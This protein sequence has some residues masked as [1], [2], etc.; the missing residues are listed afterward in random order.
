MEDNDASASIVA[1]QSPI[2]DIEIQSPPADGM[3]MMMN[4]P[5]AIHP[6]ESFNVPAAY[7]DKDIPQL[8]IMKLVRKYGAPLKMVGE[9][10][11]ILKE[12]QQRNRLDITMLTT[13]AT[14]IRRLQKMYSSLPSPVPITISHERT[15]QEM[16]SGS[17]RPS[18]TFPVFSFL[19]QLSAQRLT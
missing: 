2:R 8:R 7:Y 11:K 3:V 9:F 13:H 18:L 14:G 6:K 1:H 19:G 17:N 15:I 10:S 5:C 12:E 4:D 16:N